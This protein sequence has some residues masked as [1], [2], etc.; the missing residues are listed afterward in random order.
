MSVINIPPSH[1]LPENLTC[2][3]CDKPLTL[4][5]ASAGPTFNGEQQFICQNHVTG[6]LRELVLSWVD[7]AVTH[8]SEKQT[9]FEE[10]GVA[11]DVACLC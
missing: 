9:F 4:E 8:A 3:F 7:Y 1:V 5:S 11:Y 2:V 10:F 6:N